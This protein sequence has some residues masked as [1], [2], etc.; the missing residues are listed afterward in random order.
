MYLLKW[1]VS[2]TKSIYFIKLSQREKYPPS[3]ELFLVLFSGIRTEYGDLSVFNFVLNK[4]E[5]KIEPCRTRVD[6]LK[7]KMLV[8]YPQ[9]F[10]IM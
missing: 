10:P 4:I 9:L 8:F 5:P 6:M 1:V 7:R 3:I 2:K